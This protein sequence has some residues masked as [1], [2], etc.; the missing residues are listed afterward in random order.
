MNLK[1]VVARRALE[2]HMF[3]PGLSV[4][5]ARGD[6]LPDHLDPYLNFDHFEMTQPVFPPHPHAG[7]SA[8]TYMFPQSENGFIN[9]DSRGDRIEIL[10]GDL[11]WTAAGSGILHEETPIQRGVVCNGLQIF[12]NLHSSKKWMPPEVLHLEAGQIPRI[13]KSGGDVRVVL[14]RHGDHASPLAPPTSVTLIDVVLEPGARFE[15]AVPAGESRFLYVVSGQVECESDGAPALLNQGDVA[16]FAATGDRLAVVAPQVAAHFIVAGGTPLREP[17]VF[18]G[19]FCMNSAEDI[20]RAVR[21][22]ETGKMGRLE[23]SF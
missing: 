21:A 1:P 19:S 2:R 18:K 14:G 17:I 4:A 3:A 10:P 23:R 12:V 9:R 11:H 15:H 13:Q 6:S 16:G 5:G 22:Y 7:F 20:E 8:V